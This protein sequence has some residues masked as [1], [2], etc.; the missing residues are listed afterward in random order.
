MEG[1]HPGTV[2]RPIEAQHFRAPGLELSTGVGFD[3][4]L[5]KAPLSKNELQPP[6]TAW[7]TYWMDKIVRQCLSGLWMAS[8]KIASD[9]AIL[10]GAR[11]WG[12]GIFSLT[13]F[14]IHSFG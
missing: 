8:A 7:K 2:G 1:P 12:N 13:G 14:V 4:H 3:R 6:Q 5:Q 11:L 9:N 10:V